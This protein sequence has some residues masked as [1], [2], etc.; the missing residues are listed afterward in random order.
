MLLHKMDVLKHKVQIL[1][2]EYYNNINLMVHKVHKFN[3][4]LKNYGLYNLL[5]IIVILLKI[6]ME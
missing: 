2:L 1:L 5:L 4:V 6:K 3:Y